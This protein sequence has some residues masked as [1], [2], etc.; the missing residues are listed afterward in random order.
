MKGQ[1]PRKEQSRRP[2]NCTTAAIG[3]RQCQVGKVME[4][5]CREEQKEID[6]QKK[7]VT[8][9][10]WKDVEELCGEQSKLI[11]DEMKKGMNQRGADE[12]ARNTLEDNQTT[13]RAADS[14]LEGAFGKGREATEALEALVPEIGPGKVDDSLPDLGASD[15]LGDVK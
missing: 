10:G 3:Q 13:Q 1:K 12:D 8:I 5:G 14:G 4:C 6:G 7:R 15:N 11:T 9:C 2:G